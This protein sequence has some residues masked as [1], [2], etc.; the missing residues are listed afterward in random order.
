MVMPI[1]KLCVRYVPMEP[2][3]DERARDAVLA[4]QV[5]SI[6]NAAR[7]GHRGARPTAGCAEVS[8][9]RNDRNG[10]EDTAGK[11]SE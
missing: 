2:E 9:P 4:L 7:N 8:A 3:E 11:A 6:L 1:R 10:T 5:R